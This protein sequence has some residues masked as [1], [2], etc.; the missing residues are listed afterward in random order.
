VALAGFLALMAPCGGW[1][2]LPNEAARAALAVMTAPAADT[3]KTFLRE[4][5]MLTPRQFY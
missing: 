5:M 1:S 4:N 3:A 2:G